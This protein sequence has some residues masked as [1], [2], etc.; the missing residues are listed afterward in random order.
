M[1]VPTPSPTATSR[2]PVEELAHVVEVLVEHVGAA[3]VRD[4]ANSDQRP[5]H[6]WTAERR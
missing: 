5:L 1:T 2:S 3:L 4:E 6:V